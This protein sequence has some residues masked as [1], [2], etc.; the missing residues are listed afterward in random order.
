[1]QTPRMRLPQRPVNSVMALPDE[2]HVLGYRPLCVDLRLSSILTSHNPRKGAPTAGRSS[3]RIK[4]CEDWR[5][6]GGRGEKIA[7][8]SMLDLGRV[9]F[10]LDRPLVL[11]WI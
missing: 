8:P 7:L 1:M 11:D 3:D 10:L 4:H 5:T 2:L 6:S 9:S